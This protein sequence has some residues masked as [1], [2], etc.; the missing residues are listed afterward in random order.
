[1]ERQRMLIELQYETL[2]QLVS[3]QAAEELPRFITALLDSLQAR[4]QR[5]IPEGAIS[6]V[7][8]KTLLMY[9]DF[10]EALM[11]VNLS[12]TRVTLAP[13]VFEDRLRPNRILYA[14]IGLIMTSLLILFYQVYRNFSLHALAEELKIRRSG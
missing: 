13:T 10:G 5:I 9:Q 14:V 1:M 3:Q 2:G 11:P 12:P 4:G 7:S 8:E 6:S